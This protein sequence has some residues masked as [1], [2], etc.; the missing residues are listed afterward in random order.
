MLYRIK[1]RKGT[2]DKKNRYRKSR[3]E[4][5]EITKDEKKIEYNK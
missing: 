2:I 4:K 1:T 5:Q 3:K